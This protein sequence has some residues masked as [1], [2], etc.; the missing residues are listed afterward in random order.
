LVLLYQFS[1]FVWLM[2]VRC[3]RLVRFH[4]VL[5]CFFLFFP[6]V[7]GYICLLIDDYTG[8]SIVGLLE[9]ASIE[10]MDE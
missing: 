4:V 9:A 7:D 2:F 5:I 8:F 1:L 3:D 6:W 10:C